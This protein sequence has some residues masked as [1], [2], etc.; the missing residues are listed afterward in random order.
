MVEFLLALVLLIAL[1]TLFIILQLSGK[2]GKISVDP[3]VI[4]GAIATC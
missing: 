2:L 3:K 4:K 1:I